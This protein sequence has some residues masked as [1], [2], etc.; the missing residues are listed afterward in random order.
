RPVLAAVTTDLLAPLGARDARVENVREAPLV[1]REHLQD[2]L[3]GLLPALERGDG[4]AVALSGPSGLGQSALAA[5]LADEAQRRGIVT[6]RGRARPNERI[7]FNA[8]D[9]IVDGLARRLEHGARDELT[10]EAAA[11][12]ATAF[13][14]LAAAAERD[15]ARERTR[16]TVRAR[17]FGDAADRPPERR[18]V[19]DAVA[20]LVRTAASDR[21]ALIVVDDAQWADSDAVA[22]LRH[23]IAA[24]RG[25]VGMALVLRDDLAAGPIGSWLAG[26]R[27]L[28]RIDVPPLRD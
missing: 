9:G 26:H 6:L 1:G 24:G 12:A 2:T 15:L 27:D 28:R 19:F 25:R 22:L 8:M 23:V 13:P 7:A 10:S 3:L 18:S 21:G 14:V 16:A 11:I 20:T 4:L 5:W 17:L